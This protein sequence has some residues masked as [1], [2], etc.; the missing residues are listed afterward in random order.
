MTRVL[1]PGWSSTFDEIIRST[2]NDLLVVT[3]YYSNQVISRILKLCN[4]NVVKR[5]LLA[6]DGYE[7]ASGYQSM[8]ALRTLLRSRRTVVRTIE[9]LHA[10]VIISDRRRAVVTS[11]N[12]TIAGLESNIEFG[13]EVEESRIVRGLAESLQ[14]Y[15]ALGKNLSAS[16]LKQF[17]GQLPKVKPPPGKTEPYGPRVSTS[18]PIP[19]WILVH[20]LDYLDPDYPNP[21][22]ELQELARQLPADWLWRRARP[23]QEGGP[24]TVLFAYDWKIFARGTCM[25]SH[26]IDTDSRKQG[27]NFAFKLLALDFPKE[28]ALQKLPLGNS[29]I[30]HRDLIRLDGRALSTYDSLITK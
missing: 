9:N 8:S 11:S 12:L 26:D 15:W 3:P 19:K 13:V 29:A 30:Y 16:E 14:Y 2:Q 23:L 22:D 6:L 21:K 24:Y 7:A 1:D 4:P 27:Y 17:Q 28:V 10:K 18:R 5:F 20:S 25:V